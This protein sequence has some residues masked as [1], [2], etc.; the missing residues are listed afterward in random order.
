MPVNYST[1]DVNFTV[2]V[3]RSGYADESVVITHRKATVN[4]GS[5]T[6]DTG[7][8]SSGQ[9]MNSTSATSGNVTATFSAIAQY[10]SDSIW[11][12]RDY[13]QLNR[14]GV[15]LTINTAAIPNRKAL[16]GL[17]LTFTANNYTSTSVTVQGTSATTTSTTATSWTGEDTANETVF[18]LT[19]NN[20]SLRVTGFTVSYQYYSWE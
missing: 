11:S 4:N 19:R 16:T 1:S 6:F 20:Q 15:T 18:A 10:A 8:G 12:S 2:K 7:N 3:S 17:S 9:F 13:T 14:T 5:V